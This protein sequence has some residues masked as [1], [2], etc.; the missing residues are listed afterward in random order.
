MISIITIWFYMGDNIMFKKFI[1]K[2]REKKQ[3]RYDLSNNIRLCNQNS[4]VLD[5]C[6]LIIDYSSKI[7]EENKKKLQSVSQRHKV[8]EEND[9]LTI[10]IL[11]QFHAELDE[12][13]RED[14]RTTVY[15]NVIRDAQKEIGDSL[16][17]RKASERLLEL[18]KELDKIIEENNL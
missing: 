12:I 1:K 15:L 6:S 5:K 7:H 3:R 4:R 13:K 11:K 18:E 10:E 8:L 17:E 16:K 14:A 9:A 2:I